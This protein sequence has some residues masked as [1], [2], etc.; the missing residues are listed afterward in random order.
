MA[1][2]PLPT[3]RSSEIGR[4]GDYFRRHK[5]RSIAAPLGGIGVSFV[6]LSTDKL[7][8]DGPRKIIETLCLYFF[9]ANLALAFLFIVGIGVTQFL[10][11]I[12]LRGR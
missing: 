8:A 5:A 2:Q 9:G 6:L 4:W 12:K 1:R 11:D 10:R 3:N 7:I